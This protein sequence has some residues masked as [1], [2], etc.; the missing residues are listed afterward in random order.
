M[1]RDDS[2]RLIASL[3]TPGV[4]VFSITGALEAT[5]WPA[6]QG[7]SRICVKAVSSHS[8]FFSTVRT[9]QTMLLL[10]ELTFNFRAV[11]YQQ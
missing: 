4:D 6:V 8:G 11:Y 3:A 5:L 2:V 10:N 1:S 9:A 7:N